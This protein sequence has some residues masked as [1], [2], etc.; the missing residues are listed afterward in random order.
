MKTHNYLPFIT[1]IALS[2]GFPAAASGEAVWPQFRGPN[3][4][5]L[6]N[7]FKPPVRI[8]AD[9]PAWKTPIPPGKSSPVVCNGTIFLTGVQ[10]GRLATLAIDSKSGKLL[11][12]KPAPEVK[13]ESVHS[14]GSVAASTPCVDEQRVYAYFGSYGLLCYDH[15]GK[16]LWNKP[17]PTPQSMYGVST[18]PILHDQKLILVLDDDATLPDSKL[19]RSRVIALDK[20]TGQIAWE[21]PRPN[22]RG[23]WSSPMIWKQDHGTDLVVLGDG[24]ISGYDPAT[25]SERWLVTGF[26]REPIAVPV[27]GSGH[28]FASVA[29]QGGRGDVKLDPEPFWKAL[30]PLDRNGDG[31]IGRDEMTADFTMPLRPE[32]PLGHPGFGLP[33][34]ADPAKRKEKQEKMFDMRDKNHDGLLTRE[35]FVTDMNV[36]HGEPFLMAIRPGGTGDVT[37]T[38]VAW[39]ISSG[40][41]EIP[42]PIHHSGR[43]YLVRDGG[44]L[45]CVNATTGESIY[46]QRLGPSGQYCASPVIANDHL[47]ILSS[48]GH[49]STVATGD[50]FEILHQTDLKA[51]ISATPAMDRNS[52]YVRTDDAIM[53]F[54]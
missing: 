43:L 16:E 18:S 41:P 2:A 23:V 27:A 30:L 15:A 17:I 39:R 45:N 25:G 40:V 10:T 37:A 28:L 38:H 51:P 32:L 31:M 36:G 19:S 34:P 46:R 1:C 35:E 50:R 21:T 29:M 24:R 26:A 44:I 33:L 3:G 7:A 22:N 42:C 11:W 5:G 53:A 54:R 13:L 9:K 47:Y 12:Q 6:A 4:S 49:L 8:A 52:L 48:K 20:A 14:A